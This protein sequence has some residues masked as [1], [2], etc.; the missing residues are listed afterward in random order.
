MEINEILPRRRRGLDLASTFYKWNGIAIT[1][2]NEYIV[3]SSGGQWRLD[4]FSFKIRGFC[5]ESEGYK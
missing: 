3:G 1:K 5:R 2:L 4:P